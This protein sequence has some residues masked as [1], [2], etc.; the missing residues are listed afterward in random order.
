MAVNVIDNCRRVQSERYSDQLCF[1]YAY[2]Q[3][4]KSRKL[5][6]QRLM[7]FIPET[8]QPQSPRCPFRDMTPLVTRIELNIISP[9]IRKARD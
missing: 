4:E 2:V 6:L 7:W 1:L 5:K 9:W 3:D 8:S